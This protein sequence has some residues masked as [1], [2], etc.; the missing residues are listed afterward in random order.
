MTV[1]ILSCDKFKLVIEHDEFIL[2]KKKYEIITQGTCVIICLIQNKYFFSRFNE[3][4]IFGTWCIKPDSSAT[5]LNFMG[6]HAY[7]SKRNNRK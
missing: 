3:A 4:F 2:R 5:M 7:L 1:I 6:L